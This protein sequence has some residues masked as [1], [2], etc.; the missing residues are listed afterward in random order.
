MTRRI[1][2]TYTLLNQVTLAATSSAVTF[3]NIPQNF[4]DLVLVVSTA[5]GNLGA[6]GGTARNLLARLNNDSGANYPRVA[7][8][9]D[10]STVRY[11]NNT[12]NWLALDWYGNTN[13]GT[14]VHIIQIMDYSA[15]DKHKTVLDRVVS[16]AAAEA[17]VLRWTNTAA[18]TTI[19][20]FY[21]SNTLAAGSTFYLYGVVA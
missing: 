20:F 10:G 8:S 3:S 4:G 17:L 11:L 19:S 9:G 5:A 2:P 12:E 6:A 1:T 15:I 18:V 13:S 16:T 7:M 14:H 21:D